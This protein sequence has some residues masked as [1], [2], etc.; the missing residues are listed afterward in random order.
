MKTV[1]LLHLL[2]SRGASSFLTVKTDDQRWR[3]KLDSAAKWAA[4]RWPFCCISLSGNAQGNA[5]PPLQ[6]TFVCLCLLMCGLH[7]VRFELNA[8]AEKHFQ[9][10]FL[11]APECSP[12]LTSMPLVQPAVPYTSTGRHSGT[13]RSNPSWDMC[14]LLTFSSATVAPPM[15]RIRSQC[16]APLRL[17]GYGMTTTAPK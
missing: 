7:V 15:P 10:Y 5:P 4:C 9:V 16:S 13:A 8:C 14:I 2:K 6:Q 11:C 12:P 3:S 1:T 17:G